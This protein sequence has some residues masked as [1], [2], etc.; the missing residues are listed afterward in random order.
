MR[1]SIGGI[2]IFQIAIIFV[3]IFTAVMCITINRSKAYAVKDKVL[4]IVQTNAVR[5]GSKDKLDSE[6]IKDITNYMKESG[7]RITS[8][9]P[10][11]YTGYNRDGVETGG[12]QSVICLRA[13]SV[14]DGFDK[15]SKKIGKDDLPDMYYYDILLF[16]QIDVPIISDFFKLSLKGSTKI[17]Y[18]EGNN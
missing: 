15:Y 13:N 3:L 1:E 4:D 16:Y 6:T 2:S 10:N 14:K 7:Y 5:R 17:L 9:C 12:G 11:G 8:K 18:S